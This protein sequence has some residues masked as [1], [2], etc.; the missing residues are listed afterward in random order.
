MDELG[1]KP[2]RGKA[3]HGTPYEVFGTSGLRHDEAARL[4]DKL[5]APSTSIVS[6]AAKACTKHARRVD[7]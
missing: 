1:F 4:Y 2:N 3:Q 7:E 6:R 5:K